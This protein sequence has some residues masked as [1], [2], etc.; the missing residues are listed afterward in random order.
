MLVLNR[1]ITS[2]L[3]GV[4]PADPV[5]LVAAIG[6]LIA[7]TAAAAFVPAWR[8]STVDP[9]SPSGATEVS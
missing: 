2:R 1:L 3:F 9:R 8:A 4:S 5:T 7:V 6:L